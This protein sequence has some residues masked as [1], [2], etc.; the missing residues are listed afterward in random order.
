MSANLQENFKSEDSPKVLFEQTVKGSR[1]V[2]NYLIGAMLSIG[3]IGFLL[4]SGSSY[5]GRDL[6]PLG[7]P[8]TLIFVP[9]G[10]VMGLYGIAASLLAIYLWR[11]ISVDFGSGVN[12]FDKEAGL[13]VIKRQGFL[14]ELLVEIPLKDINAVK[15]DVR[16][17]FNS[18]RR[19][20]LRIKGRKDLPVSQIGAPQPLLELEQE[21]AQLA[22]F[23]GVGLEGF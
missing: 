10:L 20:S 13:L 1:K 8:S 21:A 15:L 14:K 23:L 3:G 2:S 19:I 4:A 17:G 22:R 11:L 16:E 12:V 9:Q 7:R 18:K 5:L 6:L